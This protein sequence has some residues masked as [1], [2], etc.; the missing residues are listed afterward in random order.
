[1]SVLAIVIVAGAVVI[2]VVLVGGFVA[3]RRRRR[4]EL[5]SG[6]FDRSLA[7]A[8]R[9]LEQARAV[10]KGW[11]RAVLEQAARAAVE[12][13]R[14]GAAYDLHLV[15]VDDRPGVSEDRCEF[16]AVGEDRLR[17]ALARRDEG[18]VA[19]RVE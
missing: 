17:V 13:A 4:A 14:P 9:A 5:E 12:E 15:L 7:E 8:D 16:L 19:E 2:L 6:A 1:M 10:D 11:D 18:W 3:V